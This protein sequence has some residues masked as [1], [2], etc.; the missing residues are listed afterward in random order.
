M[1]MPKRRSYLQPVSRTQRKREAQRLQQLGERLVALPNEQAGSIPMSE[2]LAA[3]VAEAREMHKHGARRRQLQYI[4]ALM[5]ELDC[6][7]IEKALADLSRGDR[8]EVRRFKQV[9]RWRDALVAGETAVMAEIL[10]QCPAVDADRIEGLVA[11]VGAAKTAP[12]RR[13]A[14]RSLFRYL[15]GLAS[16]PKNRNK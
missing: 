13:K 3:A 11:A 9:E 8:H 15:K 4:G 7:P 6:T 10:G 16:T 5:R 14:A 1:S 2:E 12:S